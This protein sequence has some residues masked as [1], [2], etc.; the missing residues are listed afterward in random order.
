MQDNTMNFVEFIV[1]VE[2]SCPGRAQMIK[3]YDVF[4]LKGILDEKGNV[5]SIAEKEHP[6]CDIRIL[7]VSWVPKRT[8]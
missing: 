1:T 3:D 5:L 4:H 7:D 2:I 8:E 6:G